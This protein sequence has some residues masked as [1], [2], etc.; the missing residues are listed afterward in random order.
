MHVVVHMSNYIQLQT[1]KVDG[2]EARCVHVYLIFQLIRLELSSWI[3]LGYDI[4]TY[5]CQSV[6]SCLFAR[7]HLRLGK[8][9]P[10]ME[11]RWI[12]YVVFIY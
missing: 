7:N 5:Q 2:E 6:Y 8:H 1:G 4:K 9:S 11:F 3:S 10:L 12:F